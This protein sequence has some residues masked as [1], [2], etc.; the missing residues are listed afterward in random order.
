MSED[1]GRIHHREHHEGVATLLRSVSVRLVEVSR[2]GIRMECTSRVEPGMSGQI[3]VGLRGLTRVDDVRIARCQQRAGAGPMFNVGAELLRTRP[4]SRRSV[5]MAVTG[6]IG[7][8]GPVAER[9]G[10]RSAPAEGAAE[11]KVLE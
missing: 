3:A 11:A 6:I 5:R 7:L 2:G 1:E 4:L 10:D 9:Q 8:G